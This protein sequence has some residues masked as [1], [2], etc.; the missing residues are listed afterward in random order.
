MFC[1]EY[2]LLET[3]NTTYHLQV[4]SSNMDFDLKRGHVEIIQL[5]Y[6]KI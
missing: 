1:R 4:F 6:I 2:I 5:I 3:T